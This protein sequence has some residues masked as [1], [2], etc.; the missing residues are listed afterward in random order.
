MLICDYPAADAIPLTPPMVP[1][2]YSHQVIRGK[3]AKIARMIQANLELRPQYED[4]SFF[5]LQ[6]QATAGKM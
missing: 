3:P 5:E 2:I 1:S 6:G 4:D